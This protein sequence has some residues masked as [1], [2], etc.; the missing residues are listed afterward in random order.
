MLSVSDRQ[1]R[2]AGYKQAVMETTT[3]TMLGAGGIAGEIGEGLTRKGVGTLT[4]LDPD[5]VDPTN[6]NRQ[7][8]FAADLGQNKALCLAK[9]LSAMGFFD[10]QLMGLGIS[11][12][13]AV[14]QG[15]DLACDVAIVGIDSATG[16]IAASVYFRERGIPVVF[17]AVDE[18]ANYGYVF[19]QEPGGACFVCLFP[20]SVSD[21]T[22]P[23]PGV[24]A[25]KDILKVVGGLALYAVDSVLMDR[26]RPWHYKTVYLD[27]SIPG[28]DWAVA[29]RGDCRLCGAGETTG[30]AKQQ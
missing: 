10:T 18:A 13:A 12:E 24:P 28:Q 16:R 1:E 9:N 29:K 2:V 3:A 30:A 21:T 23:C 20:D 11:F 26:P 17:T 15:V 6:L 27:G 8:F 5:T 14:D 4:M 22:D 25:V 19:V 7:L